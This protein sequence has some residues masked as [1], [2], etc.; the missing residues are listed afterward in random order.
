MMMMMMMMMI[1]GR[2]NLNKDDKEKC[3][4]KMCKITQYNF[5]GKDH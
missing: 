2:L 1:Q 3:D 4:H 5:R